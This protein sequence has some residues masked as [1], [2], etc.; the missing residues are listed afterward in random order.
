[1]SIQR[2]R[3]RSTSAAAARIK[4]SIPSTRTVALAAALRESPASVELEVFLNVSSG[5]VRHQRFEHHAT[6]PRIG[7]YH[8]AK[9]AP[10]PDPPDHRAPPRHRGI[11]AADRSPQPRAVRAATRRAQ[12]GGR[13][14]IILGAARSRLEHEDPIRR[15]AAQPICK[16]TPCRA[17]SDDDDIVIH[18]ET[19]NSNPAVQE[20]CSGGAENRLPKGFKGREKV[21]RSEAGTCAVGGQQ[22]FGGSS[23][24]AA[25]ESI[26]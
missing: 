2:R 22:R 19:L 10:C 23:S 11:E 3:V 9:A 15:I 14:K 20:H 17:S 18:I 1:M 13:Q 26:F 5:I 8:L 21:V 25:L 12:P 7:Y 16:D 24:G 4:G 6:N